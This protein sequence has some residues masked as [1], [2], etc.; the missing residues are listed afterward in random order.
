MLS[1]VRAYGEGLG[2]VEQIPTKILPDAIKNTATKIAH[3]GPAADDRGVLAGAMV[4]TEEQSLA[5]AALR[6]GEALVHVERHPL[7]FRVDAPTPSGERG[8]GMG[9]MGDEEVSGLSAE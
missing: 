3:R 4:M 6:P 2:V 8:I 5:L 9:G 7:P 1:E